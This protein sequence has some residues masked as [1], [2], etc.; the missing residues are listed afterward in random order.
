MQARFT[1][2]LSSGVTCSRSSVDVMGWFPA[3][4]SAI[5]TKASASQSSTISGRGPRV[6][7]GSRPW[8]TLLI[9]RSS[10]Q[11]NPR[12]KALG[13]MEIVGREGAKRSTECIPE[14][15]SGK[16]V[17]P[18]LPRGAESFGDRGNVVR[19]GVL[20]LHN[21][22]PAPLEC[23]QPYDER[24]VTDAVPETR[25]GI[26]QGMSAWTHSGSKIPLAFHRAKLSG[27]F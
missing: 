19:D 23:S 17:E 5:Q 10:L 6:S 7:G 14:D 25:L 16:L 3:A 26:G 24:P 27:T 18:R 9:T 12:A 4:R 20:A 11:S 15:R 21:E 2:K 13:Q 1:E 22:L 8:T